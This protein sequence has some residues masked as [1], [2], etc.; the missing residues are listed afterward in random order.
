MNTDFDAIVVGGG[1]LGIAHAYALLNRGLKVALFERNDEPMDASVRNFGQIVPSGFGVEWQKYGRKSLEIYQSIQREYDITLRQQG[2]LYIASDVEELTLLEELATINRSNDYTSNLKTKSECLAHVPGLREEY[3]QGGLF[4]PE[5]VNL[6][7]RVAIARIIQACIQKF[8]LSYFPNT[9]IISVVE[10]N[11][12]VEVVSAKG[13]RYR[14]SLALVCSG[15]DFE[16]LF[17]EVYDKSDL[18]LVKIQM[19]ATVPQST[20]KLPG[21]ILTG[22][23][24]RRY[25]SFYDCPSYKEIKSK[26]ENSAYYKQHGIHILFKQSPDGSV[27]IGDSHHYADITQ[28]SHIGFDVENEINH[29]IVDAAKKII[30]LEDYQIQRTWIGLYSQCKNRAIFNH[31]I[32]QSIHINT[33]IGGK[34]MTASFGYADAYIDDIL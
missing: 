22:W 6:H 29:F 14:A 25:E 3:V 10:N 11:N 24:I 23:S 5:E 15:A 26:E 19:M 12:G 33:G 13:G 27:V 32:G 17:P 7:P 4:F 31:K 28:R 20:L 21:S 18:Q 16:T 1:I 8:E 30:D 9:T 2:S 34:G